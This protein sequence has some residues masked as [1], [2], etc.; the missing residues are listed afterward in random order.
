MQFIGVVDSTDKVNAYKRFIDITRQNNYQFIPKHMLDLKLTG[1]EPILAL[2]F[3]IRADW[4]TW[5]A[6][7]GEWLVQKHEIV[8]GPMTYDFTLAKDDSDGKIVHLRLTDR[9][10]RNSQTTTYIGTNDYLKYICDSLNVETCKFSKT[11]YRLDDRLTSI[12]VN[13]LEDLPQS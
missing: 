5:N 3:L 4:G 6:N 10:E 12:W 7:C 1:S 13:T 8:D 9:R 11:L 2:A